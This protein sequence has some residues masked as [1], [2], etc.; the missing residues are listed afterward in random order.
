ML[1]ITKLITEPL[2]EFT[3]ND[4]KQVVGYTRAE[5]L[6]R[7]ATID[8]QNGDTRVEEQALLLLDEALY[9]K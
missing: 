2:I 4:T 9:N 5:I 6:A 1:T 3:I 7:V 8:S